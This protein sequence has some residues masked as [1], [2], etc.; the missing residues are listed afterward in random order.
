MTTI[1]IILQ[2]LC[3]TG[4]GYCKSVMDL[5]QPENLLKYKGAKWDKNIDEADKTTWYYKWFPK[6]KWHEFEYYR[7]LFISLNLAPV[8]LLA[9]T[10]P[11]DNIYLFIIGEVAGSMIV[12]ATA[13]YVIYNFWKKRLTK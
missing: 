4:A 9:R 7:I 13:F 3:L 2:A 6:G 10:A 5:I 11:I 12:F 1:L 8:I